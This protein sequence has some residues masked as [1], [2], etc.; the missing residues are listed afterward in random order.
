M[1][2]TG[3]TIKQRRNEGEAD[4]T[5]QPTKVWRVYLNGEL[6]VTEK[7]YI[8]T[9]PANGEP[10]ARMSNVGRPVV[11]QAIRDSYEAVLTWRQLPGKKRGEWLQQIAN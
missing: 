7:T 10:V 6:T 5:D 1:T 3:G 2:K 4:G 9:N 11:A 8:V